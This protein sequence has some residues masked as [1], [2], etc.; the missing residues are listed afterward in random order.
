[1]R[2]FLKINDSNFLSE[3]LS[4][5]YM[6]DEEK[7]DYD[8]ESQRFLCIRQRPF[9]FDPVNGYENPFLKQNS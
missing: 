2:I 8:D 6:R 7:F 9:L 5:F 3:L 4:H 1:M